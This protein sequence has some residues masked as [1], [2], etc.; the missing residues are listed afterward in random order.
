MSEQQEHT[1]GAVVRIS[2]IVGSSPN[3]FS[4]AVRTAVQAAAQTVR[5]IRGVEVISS[6]A[7]VDENGNLTMYKVNCKIAFVVE[8]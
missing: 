2:E 3:S 1:P 7:D 4:D 6:N 8:R 5:N